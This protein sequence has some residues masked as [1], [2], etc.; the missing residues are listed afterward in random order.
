MDPAI[1]A[2]SEGHGPTKPKTY[3]TQSDSSKAPS[4]SL[5]H[6]AQGRP[7][8]EE[9]AKGQQYLIPSEEKA[10]V[11]YVLRTSGSGYPNPVKY[12]RSLAFI[13]AGQHSIDNLI[14]YPGKNWPQAFYKCH[15]QFK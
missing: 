7:S 6:G 1:I 12:L 3:A 14:K 5:W 11:K 9:K 15:L 2:L 8:R 10:L 13:I 4:S